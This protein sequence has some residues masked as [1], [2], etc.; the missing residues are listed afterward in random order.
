MSICVTSDRHEPDPD[1]DPEL[2][3]KERAEAIVADLAD[4]PRRKVGTR[5]LIDIFALAI[6][7]AED[8][9]VHFSANLIAGRVAHW[10]G[11]MTAWKHQQARHEARILHDE[12]SRLLRDVGSLYNADD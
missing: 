9:G 2:T 12:T 10:E 5:E 4:R 6:A 7:D 3:P 8:R 1:P 11:R